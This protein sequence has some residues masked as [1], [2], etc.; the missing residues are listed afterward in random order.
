MTGRCFLIAEVGIN[1]NGDPA[2]ACE[3]VRAAAGAGADAVKFQAFSAEQFVTADAVVYG[4]DKGGLP[5]RQIDMLAA[6][7]FTEDAWRRIRDAAADA[8][9]TFFAS[10]FDR[11]NLNL[12][13]RLGAPLYKIA[14]CDL[15][16]LRL[17]R[18]V[19]ATG[20]PVLLSTGMGTLQEV[21]AAVD[22]FGDGAAERLTLMQCTSSYPSR[23]ADAHLRV[24]GSLREAFGVRV[25]FSDHCQAN[26]VAFAAAALGAS[27]I[28]KHFTSDTSLPGVD[29]KM[30]LSPAEF[31]DLVHGVRDIE[32]A[33]G[34][35]HKRPLEVE[36]AARQNGRRSLVAAGDIPAGT[37]L[38]PDML[39][40]K[41]P[42]TG[43]SPA[44]LDT[45]IGRRTSRAIRRDEPIAWDA[46]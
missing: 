13:E 8:G 45:L 5:T 29:Q 2:L 42:G 4:D 23:A 30:S 7:E 24:M 44:M 31:A 14:S 15:T 10:V 18:A 39:V 1:H 40:A 11:D 32:Q 37:V 17:V 27:A 38:Q 21:A 6:Y 26:Y 22:A 36:A 16:N 43:I 28:E 41:R 20:K 19:A 46:V 35:P 3:M 34:S 25:G 12:F 9:V 33:L